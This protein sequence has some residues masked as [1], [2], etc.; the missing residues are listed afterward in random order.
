MKKKLEM[1]NSDIKVGSQAIP[2]KTPPRQK[3]ALVPS[4]QEM[5]AYSRLEPR[6]A[7]KG[8]IVAF[9]GEL[10]NIENGITPFAEDGNGHFDVTQAILLTQKAYWNVPIFR[11][12]IDVQSEISNSPLTWTGN[13]KSVKFF[14]EWWA[15]VGGYNTT[16]MFFRE[17]FRSSNP[18]FYRIDAPSGIKKK[19]SRK[20]ANG[21][22]KVEF[23]DEAESCE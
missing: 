2:L 1:F 7:K 16:A 11:S 21:E 6:G 10:S 20:L 9:N 8:L 4:T 17:W 22:T 18:M 19:V 15:S 5:F 23:N 13:K 12:T 14:K 3:A